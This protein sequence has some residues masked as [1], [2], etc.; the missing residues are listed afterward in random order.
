MADAPP[1]TVPGSD[2]PK[3]ADID[4]LLERDYSWNKGLSAVDQPFC[5]EWARLKDLR[6][7]RGALFPANKAALVSLC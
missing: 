4:V 1:A 6:L 7:S 5:S 2:I 3:L